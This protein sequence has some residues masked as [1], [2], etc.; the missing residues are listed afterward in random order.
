MTETTAA[1]ESG[2]D[3]SENVDPQSS[4][5]TAEET[6]AAQ[7][8]AIHPLVLLTRPLLIQLSS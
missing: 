1:K 6:A 3:A 2:A 5:P 4:E 7:V 8:R